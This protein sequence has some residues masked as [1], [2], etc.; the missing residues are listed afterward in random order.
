[1]EQQECDF[2]LEEGVCMLG[3]FHTTPWGCKT[4]GSSA[5]GALLC[6][7]HSLQS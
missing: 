2:P 6:E 7:V 5:G 1:M 4:Q 3:R